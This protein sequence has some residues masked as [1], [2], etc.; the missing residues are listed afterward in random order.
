MVAGSG[1]GLYICKSLIEA[2]H[3]YIGIETDEARSGNTFWF[4]LPKRAA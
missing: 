4:T 1:L 3:G 2:M